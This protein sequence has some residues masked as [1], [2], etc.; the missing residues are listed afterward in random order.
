MYDKSRN[1]EQQEKPFTDTREAL[2]DRRVNH[3]CRNTKELLKNEEIDIN[4]LSNLSDHKIIRYKYPKA[5]NT[6]YQIDYQRMK[7]LQEQLEKRK[8]RG[9]NTSEDCFNLDKEKL[10][11]RDNSNKM[12]LQTTTRQDYKDFKVLLKSK[13]R[14]QSVEQ[15][16]GL[17][18]DD[19][20]MVVNYELK[21]NYGNDSHG[22]Q[23]TMSFKSPFF[24]KSTYQNNFHDMKLMNNM[25]A[26]HPKQ[27]YYPLPWKGDT[28]YRDSFVKN[29]AENQIKARELNHGLSA[30]SLDPKQI[31]QKVTADHIKPKIVL[32]K[33]QRADLDKMSPEEFMKQGKLLC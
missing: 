8:L 14:S 9:S 4:G 3:I 23:S 12:I 20:K 27:H 10:K 24:N 5:I 32:G 26:K 7:A 6:V 19:G 2:M 11:F 18:G 25:F 28:V 17:M 33:I 29:S 13:R 31:K 21:R 1:I 30:P 15:Q 22:F 16:D